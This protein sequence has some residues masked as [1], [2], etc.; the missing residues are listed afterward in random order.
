[1]L[2]LK[3]R[4][5]AIGGTIRLDSRPGGGT[6]LIAELPFGSGSG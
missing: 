1:L 6:R 4:A 2:G 3:D 5:E